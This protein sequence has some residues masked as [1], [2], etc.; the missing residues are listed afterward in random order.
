MPRARAST[1]TRLAPLGR[2]KKQP[3]HFDDPRGRV[4]R[5]RLTA[6]AGAPRQ[7]WARE[8]SATLRAERQRNEAR[9]LVGASSDDEFRCS[10]A[11]FN[12]LSDLPRADASRP[13]EDGR[14]LAHLAFERGAVFMLA[15]YGRVRAAVAVARRLAPARR[16]RR[17]ARRRRAKVF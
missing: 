11:L 1:T 17:R 7:A 4:A 13:F 6:D 8:L 9:A 5:R 16:R 12:V 3:S 14:T 10:A 2:R 15:A